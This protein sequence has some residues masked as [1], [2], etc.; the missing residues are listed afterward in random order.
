MSRN[1]KVHCPPEWEK[2]DNW[3]R[4]EV[5]VVSYVNADNEQDAQYQIERDLNAGDI[6]EWK[7]EYVEQDINYY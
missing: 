1:D 4:V 5:N 3:F 6:D 7:V 2:E